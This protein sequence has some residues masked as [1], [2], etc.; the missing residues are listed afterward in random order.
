MTFKVITG[1]NTGSPKTSRAILSLVGSKP[2]RTAVNYVPN[3]VTNAWKT[4]DGN[5]VFTF[6]CPMSNEF[7]NAVQMA[8]EGCGIGD[9]YDVEPVL[10]RVVVTLREASDEQ[11][12]S[13]DFTMAY[14]LM[15]PSSVAN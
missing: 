9:D 8:V 15:N 14:L 2:K 12:K 13:F 3:H 5:Y 4:R 11:A 7:V 10:S 1:G 6:G